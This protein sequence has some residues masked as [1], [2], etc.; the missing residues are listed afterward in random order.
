MSD[1]KIDDTIDK[2][3]EIAHEKGIGDDDEN[4]MHTAWKN[5]DQAIEEEKESPYFF[6]LLF[7]KSIE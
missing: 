5:V 2:V 3:L 6:W 7:G 4:G 1:P